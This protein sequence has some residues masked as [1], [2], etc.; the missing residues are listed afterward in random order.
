MSATQSGV[1]PVGVQD[2]NART[3]TWKLVLA[4]TYQLYAQKFWAYFRIAI[5]P[6]AIA[7][8]FNYLSRTVVRNLARNGF[9]TVYGAKSLAAVTAIQWTR[10]IIFWIISAFFFAAIAATFVLEGP[11]GPPAVADA[12]TLPRR[13][14][15]AVAVVA[16]VTGTLFYVGRALA[17]LAVFNLLDRIAPRNYWA[18]FCG[19]G[20]MFLALATLLCKFGL[21]IP[22]LMHSPGSTAGS[23]MKKSLK[24]TEG[25]EVF[26]AMFLLKSAAIGYGIY[27]VANKGLD[28][29]WQHTTV[30]ANAYN[31]IQSSV[32]IFIAAVVETPLFIAFAVLYTELQAKDED[33]EP[34]AI[35]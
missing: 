3:V 34:S 8:G 18:G 23:A 22:K 11:D 6:A 25:W 27:W 9:F 2:P 17:G 32:Y 24:E 4:R 14:L 21:A 35:H 5:V 7:Y 29:F 12:Y 33:R 10:S 15:G 19:F 31:W 26:F 13:R 28:L 30:S 16:L 1:Q 20:L